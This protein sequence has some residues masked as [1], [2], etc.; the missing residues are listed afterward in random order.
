VKQ[1]EK[2][3]AALVM[4]YGLDKVVRA[5]ESAIHRPKAPLILLDKAQSLPMED[6]APF[7]QFAAEFLAKSDGNAWEA[8]RA[9]DNSAACGGRVWLESLRSK[10]A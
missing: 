6:R 8:C 9:W 5:A 3:I 7:Y 10:V 2:Q 1:L 4:E